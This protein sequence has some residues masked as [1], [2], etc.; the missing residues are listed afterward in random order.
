MLPMRDSTKGQARRSK[1]IGVYMRA[2]SMTVEQYNEI[3]EKLMSASGGE[4]DGLIMH[5]CFREG[6]SLAVFD[7]WES[8]EKFEAMAPVLMP[9]VAEV[10]VE[11]S[12]PQFVEMIDY[13]VV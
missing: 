7:V 1:M 13:Q 4:P 3:N 10:K 6:E 5:T 11:M 12:P 2:P 8:Q 9:I